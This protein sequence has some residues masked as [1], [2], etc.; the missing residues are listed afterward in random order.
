MV[1]ILVQ[2]LLPIIANAYILPVSEGSG[3]ARRV[4]GNMHPGFYIPNISFLNQFRKKLRLAQ[5]TSL[6]GGGL[7]K[8][9]LLL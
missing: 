6:K 5:V 8:C 4:K 9:L 3:Q 2:G 7:A 1:C